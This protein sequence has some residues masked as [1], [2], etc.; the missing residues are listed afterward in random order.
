MDL[1]PLEKELLEACREALL[2]MDRD[3]TYQKHES[4][5]IAI[6]LASRLAHCGLQK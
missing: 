6:L 2:V 3:W 4:R 1:T 5:E